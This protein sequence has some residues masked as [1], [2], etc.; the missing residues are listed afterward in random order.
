MNDE[1][2]ICKGIQQSLHER[3]LQFGVFQFSSVLCAFFAFVFAFVPNMK[4]CRLLFVNLHIQFKL[5]KIKN[6]KVSSKNLLF[7]I[8]SYLPGLLLTHIWTFME[9]EN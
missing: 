3:W 2:I 7:Y 6:R 5:G 9:N 4:T 1:G 8:L